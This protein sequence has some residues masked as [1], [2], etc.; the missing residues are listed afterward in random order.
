MLIVL[1]NMK[2]ACSYP[3]L[4]P[5]PSSSSS[6]TQQPLKF[7]HG[8][9]LNRCQLCSVQISWSPSLYTH[10]PHTLSFFAR[11]SP[12]IISASL[13]SQHYYFLRWGYQPHAQPKPQGPG[14]YFCV[15]SCK[16]VVKCLKSSPY[17]FLVGHSLSGSSAETCLPWVTPFSPT[18]HS[19]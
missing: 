4:P 3:L 15:C 7:G 16:E 6:S 12:L 19:L 8:F 5:P 2:S 1:I 10:I 18:C 13:A 11:S 17:S 9:L 14:I